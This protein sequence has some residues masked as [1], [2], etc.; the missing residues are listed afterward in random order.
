[1]GKEGGSYPNIVFCLGNGQSSVG[2]DLKKLRQ[3]GKVY[4]CNAIYRT[5]PDDIDVLVGVDQGIMHEMYHSGIVKRYQHILETGQ[6]CLLNY[7]RI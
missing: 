6:K 5:N 3:H 4:G 7:M 2:V 1:M